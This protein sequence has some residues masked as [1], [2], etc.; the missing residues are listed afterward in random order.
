MIDIFYV[1]SVK[2]LRLIALRYQACRRVTF[3]EEPPTYTTPK[4]QPHKNIDCARLEWREGPASIHIYIIYSRRR[5]YWCDLF[6][7]KSK[8]RALIWHKPDLSIIISNK[9]MTF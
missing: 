4:H 6:Y 7:G 3:S 8:L 9:V 1:I 2:K 5:N